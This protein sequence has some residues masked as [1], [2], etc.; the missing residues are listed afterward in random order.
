MKLFLAQ[1]K[2]KYRLFLSL[3][4]V[5]VISFYP[6]VQNT[7]AASQRSGEV[8]GTNHSGSPCDQLPDP[9]GKASGIDKTCP[10]AGSSSGV[11]KG[12]FNG[13]G[14]ADLAIGEPGA[15]IGGAAG[16]GD[17][18]VIYGSANGLST[19]N[20]GPELWDLGRIS[21]SSGSG[22][23]SIKGSAGDR[24]GT[25]LASGD[26]DGD[27][28]SDLAIGIPGRSV[29]QRGS[30]SNAAGAGAVVILF[31]SKNGLTT[32]RAQ[33]FDMNS[34]YEFNLP[35]TCGSFGQECPFNSTSDAGN[36][37]GQALAWGDFD[38]DG[39]GDLAIGIPG[40]DH[41]SSS[42]N[43]GGIVWVIRGSP[44][45]LNPTVFTSDGS[46][47]PGTFS[48]VIKGLGV[49][50]DRFGRVLAAGD[51][52]GDGLSDLAIGVPNR[53][54]AGHTA[55][56]AVAVSYHPFGFLGHGV[57][58]QVWNQDNSIGTGV[59]DSFDHFGASL[60][61][62]DFNGDGKTD[63]A[64]GVPFKT[65]NG[66]SDAGAVIVLKGAANGLTTT[67]VQLW[68][69]SSL[70]LPD[71]TAALF[72]LA[73]AAGDFN[74][75]LKTDLAVGAPFKDV[76]VTHTDH[77]PGVGT[78]TTTT[79]LQ[80]A[81][82]VAVIYG[83]SSGLSVTAV[84]APQIF[85][86]EKISPGS[87]QAGSRFGSS[88]TA[89]NFGRDEF[90]FFLNRVFRVQTPD[91]AIGAPFKKVNGLAAAG[92]VDVIYGSSHLFSNGLQFGNPNIFTADSVGFGSLANAHF[93]AALY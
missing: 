3:L 39:I 54:V 69:L 27:G 1:R 28:F 79:K 73:L 23:V 53:T 75:D 10:P 63:L 11:V 85:D 68:A 80:D 40:Y 76:T 82:Q 18:I 15:T 51:F 36:N 84:R 17:V 89:W 46:I 61:A 34:F 9:P 43:N 60:A 5:S 77:F 32:D 92:A 38:G 50:G 31:G 47:I 70:A 64:I 42:S 33:Y 8:P 12:D 49:A 66:V 29:L 58:D 26:F 81:G 56:G 44:R 4:L 21:L 30:T 25:A 2:S 22:S 7:K 93:G 48:S 19:T 74:G 62:G 35:I 83:S 13:D 41:D 67:G 91:L 78:I 71:E 90:F 14:F 6:V 45:G 52:N 86:E 65:I 20:N 37:L 88:L 72:G 16:A 57:I 55:A 24:F 87:A 59:S